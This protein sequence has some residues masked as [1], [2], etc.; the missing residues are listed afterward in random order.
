MKTTA[1]LSSKVLLVTWLL[2]ST[3]GCTKPAGGGGES[4]P[5]T[6]ASSSPVAQAAQG[7]F[8]PQ[9]REGF[10]VREW[11]KVP[12]ARSLALSPDGKTLFVGSR[13]G[14]VHKVTLGGEAPKV[15]KFQEKLNGSNGVC[16]VGE[17]LYLGELERVRR[18]AGKEGFPL[19]AEGEVVLEGLPAETHHGWRYMKAGPDNR[20][21]IGIGAPCN[22]CE[23][24]DDE[25][26]AT[27]CSFTPEGK[28]FRVDAAGVR[29][30][31]G[32]DWHPASGD[33]YFTD[34]GRDLMGDDVPPCELNRLPKG[35]SGRHYGFPYRWG[36]NQPDPEYGDKAPQGIDF[37]APVVDMQAHV[38]PL[39]CHFPRHQNLAK[40]KE[41]ILICQHGSWNRS[42][43]VGY[44]VVSVDLS[45][46]EKKPEPFLF[47]FLQ[48]DGTRHGRPV[49]VLELKDGTVLVSDDEGG[50]IWAVTPKK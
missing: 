1:H 27:L 15:E 20:I 9:V 28:D 11:A 48:E 34:N 44:Q 10:E 43:P 13:S 8:V 14:F 21:Y 42:S 37:V 35:E 12:D 45:Q 32:F 30:T 40:L 16:F 41:Q 23:R 24:P 18:F 3:S 38:A 46:E 26:F 17:D 29:N 31:V 5:A 47:G 49:D 2:L 6:S 19:N 7:Q 33:L 50:K 39:G 4:A 22:V 25:R 36:A